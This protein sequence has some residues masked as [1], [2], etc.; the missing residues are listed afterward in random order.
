M[1]VWCASHGYNLLLKAFGNINGID[2]LIEDIKF[3]I[4]SVR[5]HG[6]PRNI[7]QDL[8]RLGVL[9]WCITHFGTIFICMERLLERENAPR[10]LVLHKK[11]EYFSESSTYGDTKEKAV[12]FRNLVKGGGHRQK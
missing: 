6:I 2:D 8:H 4:N 5:N 9:V 3:V 7:L 11:W 10:L 1:C 12:R